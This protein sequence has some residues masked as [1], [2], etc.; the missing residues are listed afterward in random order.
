MCGRVT[1]HLVQRLWVPVYKAESVT[2]PKGEHIFG[3]K[4]MF[5]WELFYVS[6]SR[7][8]NF[9]VQCVNSTGLLHMS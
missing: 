9:R 8:S 6:L 5:L 7:I 4:T 1:K 2:T 3:R